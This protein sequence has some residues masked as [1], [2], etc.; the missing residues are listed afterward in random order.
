MV[1]MKP[2]EWMGYSV[3][4]NDLLPGAEELMDRFEQAQVPLDDTFGS[5]SDPPV[6]PPPLT[7][8]F[9]PDVEPLRLLAVLHLLRD[10]NVR[11]LLAGIETE[12]RKRILIGAYNHEREKLTPYSDELLRQIGSP[13]VTADGLTTLVREAARLREVRQ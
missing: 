1:L 9:G 6:P 11:F 3:E 10:V 8:F 7:V 12:D 5:S 13:G 2:R 4:L